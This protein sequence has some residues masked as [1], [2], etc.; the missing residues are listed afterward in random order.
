MTAMDNK[1]LA[2]FEDGDFFVRQ[3]NIKRHGIRYK[4]LKNRILKFH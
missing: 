2:V 4:T 1:E 3:T